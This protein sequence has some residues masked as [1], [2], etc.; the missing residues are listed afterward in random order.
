[1][2]RVTVEKCLTR[3]K[4]RFELVRVASRRTRQLTLGGKVPLV[5]EENDK[6]PVIALREIEEGYITADILNEK[7]EPE[8]SHDILINPEISAFNDPDMK[9]DDLDS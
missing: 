8:Y 6:P 4:N 5:P 7:D 9:I 2:A 3:V 1:M